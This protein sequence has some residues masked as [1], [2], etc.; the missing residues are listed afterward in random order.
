[1]RKVLVVL[2]D[3]FGDVA[4]FDLYNGNSC[5]DYLMELGQLQNFAFLFNNSAKGLM[6]PVEPGL[7]CGSDTA[8]LSL[9]GYDPKVW[10]RGRGAFECLGAGIPMASGELAFKC[11]FALQLDD[12]HLLRCPLEEFSGI[13][14]E[15]VS[16]LNESIFLPE[17]PLHSVRIYHQKKHRCIV[18]ISGP[19]L[20]SDITGTDPLKDNLPLLECKPMERE[21]NNVS[22]SSSFKQNTSCTF[23]DSPS[24]LEDAQFTSALVNALNKEISQLLTNHPVNSPT[25]KTNVILFRGAAMKQDFPSFSSVNSMSAFMISNT[26]I[27]SGIGKSIGM[28]VFSVGLQDEGKNIFECKFEKAFQLLSDDKYSFGFVHIKALDETCHLGNFHLRLQATIEIDKAFEALIEQIDEWKNGE[29]SLIV[30][31]D[32]TSICLTK[33]HS[34]EPVP[35]ILYPKERIG[36]ISLGRFPGSQF[37]PIVRYLLNIA[38]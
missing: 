25:C 17:F 27:I 18:V 3:G 26:C 2:L 16:Y 5:Q 8:H 19:Q 30:T 36:D 6:D 11:N 32:H 9:L 1:M 35:F 14:R 4:N 28:D 12:S 13:A 20:S 37:I 33:D 31:G 10:Y 21:M 22:S 34:V 23:N 38:S 7:A 24:S 29:I 15:L